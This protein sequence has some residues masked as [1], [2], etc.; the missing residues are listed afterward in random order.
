MGRLIFQLINEVQTSPT[1]IDGRER[2]PSRSMLLSTDV[3]V[4]TLLCHLRPS[5]KQSLLE[6]HRKALTSLM[7]RK[8]FSEASSDQVQRLLIRLHLEE[9]CQSSNSLP[10]NS[11]CIKMLSNLLFSIAEVPCEKFACLC[12]GAA[13]NQSEVIDEAQACSKFIKPGEYCFTQCHRRRA[14]YV[15]GSSLK[16][17]IFPA[18][19]DNH[20]VSNMNKAQLSTIVD[21]VLKIVRAIEL[22]SFCPHM[23]WHAFLTAS[24][25]EPS[26]GGNEPPSGTNDN[27]LSVVSELGSSFQLL[28]AHS[29][30]CFQKQR[31]KRLGAG[32]QTPKSSINDSSVGLGKHVKPGR[33]LQPSLGGRGGRGT[34]GLTLSSK[35]KSR[36]QGRGGGIS[37]TAARQANSS[38]NS[39]DNQNVAK[40]L[41]SG[42]RATSRESLPARSPDEGIDPGLLC[43]FQTNAFLRRGV[44][45]REILMQW[46]VAFVTDTPNEV[47]KARVTDDD[48]NKDCSNSLADVD[49]AQ[50]T[51]GRKDDAMNL[52][53]LSSHGRPRSSSSGDD[54]IDKQGPTIPVMINFV[55]KIFAFN[56]TELRISAHVDAQDVDFCRDT[57][58]LTSG[59]LT[60]LAKSISGI[61]ALEQLLFTYHSAKHFGKRFCSIHTTKICD[62]MQ[63]GLSFLE[64]LSRNQSAFSAISFAENEK[65]FTRSSMNVYNCSPLIISG[66]NL[67]ELTIRKALQTSCL[68]ETC[69]K[70]KGKSTGILINSADVRHKLDIIFSNLLTFMYG[71]LFPN[72]LLC[73]NCQFMIWSS[74]K[75][76]NVYLGKA[77]LTL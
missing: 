51:K 62:S 47:V 4:I 66:L 75:A 36:T 12:H 31:D 25:L 29:I 11:D 38:K 46:F 68:H 3:Q 39:L 49:C 23:F 63:C 24:K 53:I 42:S 58:L 65:N 1:V 21:D 61:V 77:K 43:E 71:S 37:L 40:H 44:L 64:P 10:G 52:R 16:D 50:A 15:L 74:W 67:L 45:V 76:A 20:V 13:S 48:M 30:M 72:S 54:K 8:E 17:I 26:V 27:F 60:S 5:L 56:P 19:S 70:A 18:F 69:H 2:T 7:K 33:V 34:A 28:Y 55:Q 35:N 6:I 32:Q 14:S 41:A 22:P 73:V 57:F 59:L 9:S